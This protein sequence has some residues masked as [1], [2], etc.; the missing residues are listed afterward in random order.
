[1]ALTANQELG[2]FVDQELR[3]YPVL[4]AVHIFKGAFVGRDAVTGMVRP[5]VAGDAFEGI[6]YEEIDNSAGQ[7][8]DRSVRVFTLGDFKIALAGAA[9]TDRGATVYASDDATATLSSVGNSAIGRL[10]AL[11]GTGNIVLRLATA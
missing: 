7:D 8:G 5:L 11:E 6:A 10:L 4:A 9:A 2:R 3:S 1:M